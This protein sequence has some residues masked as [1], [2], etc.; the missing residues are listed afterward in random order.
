MNPH[1]QRAQMLFNRSRYA[2]AERE[3]GMAL[4]VNPHEPWA[5]ALLGACRAA[6]DDF[7]KADE[8]GKQALALAPDSADIRH[9]VARIQLAR[10]DLSAALQTATE[11]IELDP[12]DAEHYATRAAVHAQQKKWDLALADCDSALAID[13]ENVDA[14]NVR[15]HARRAN[16]DMQ[17]ATAELRQ[18]LEVDPD[19]P[20]SHANL[21]WTYLQRG[22]LKQAETH[23]REALRLDPE[24]EVAR[25]G[26]LETLKAK[27]PVYR[28]ILNYFLWMQTKAA[29]AQWGILIGLYVL[30]RILSGIAANNP[31]IAP[32]IVPF[33]VLYALFA[34]ATWFAKPLAD[35]ALMFHPFGRMALTPQEKREGLIVAGLIATVLLLFG[36]DRATGVSGFFV[37]GILIIPPG[38]AL[39]MSFNFKTPQPRRILQLASA[40][41]TVLSLF[42]ASDLLTPM[43]RSFLP[44]PPYEQMVPIY[45]RTVSLSILAVLI[46]TNVLATKQWRR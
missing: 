9:L 30:Y 2:D 38:L 26:V 20:Y 8:L 44:L 10:N 18:A 27:V 39:A 25:V 32:F 11:T 22:D 16:G 31:S 14:L 21:G 29:A 17:T 7:A 36:I 13:P 3:L 28:W 12:H 6:Q 41:L 15:S 1:I 40:G 45:I 34:L 24:L 4:Q 35:A 19:D 42:I 43:W 46:G 33:L 5:Y 23:F 37:V